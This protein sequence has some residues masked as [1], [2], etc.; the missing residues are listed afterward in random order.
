MLSVPYDRG[1]RVIL[2]GTPVKTYCVNGGM[3]GIAVTPG[4]NDIQMWFA[5]RGLKAGE[6]CTAAGILLFAGVIVLDRKRRKNSSQ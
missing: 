2:N 5:P 3:T 1:W 4:E 6:F